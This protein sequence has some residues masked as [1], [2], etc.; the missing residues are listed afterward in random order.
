MNGRERISSEIVGDK[1]TEEKKTNSVEEKGG[2]KG[3]RKK[4]RGSKRLGDERK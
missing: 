2:G 4:I 3:K 1:R